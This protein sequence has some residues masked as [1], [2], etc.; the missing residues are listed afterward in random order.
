[1]DTR[2]INYDGF[3]AEMC[4]FAGASSIPSRDV[5]QKT[6]FAQNIWMMSPEPCLLIAGSVCRQVSQSIT[7]VVTPSLSPLGRVKGRLHL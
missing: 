6:G 3:A 2:L 7:I 4:L 5:Q 1:M